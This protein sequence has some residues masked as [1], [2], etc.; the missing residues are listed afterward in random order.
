MTEIEISTGASSALTAKTW[1]SISWQK[2]DKQVTRL[3]MRIAKAER[4][5]K[6]GKVKALQRILTC[7]FYAKC[8]AVKRV[9]S[10]KGGKTP[11]VDGIIWKTAKQKIQATLSLKRHGYN[12]LPSR[13]INVPKKQKGKFR[14]IS[15]PTMKDKAMQALWHMALLPIAEERS[16]LN[17]YGFR[18]KR[19]T[20]DAIEQ[21]F[22]AL[23]KNE[24]PKWVFEGDIRSCFDKISHQW[25]LE[26]IPMDKQILRKFLKAGFM[27]KQ[28]L[29]PT[30]LGTEQG[31]TISPTLAIMALSGIE[32]KVR[33]TSSRQR[34]KE[35]INFVSYADDFIIT[36]NSPELLKGKV[37]PIVTEFLAERGLELSQEKSKI[38]H[39]DEGF[40]FLGL[41]VRKY[42]GKLLIK[43]AK[44]NIKTFLQDIRSAIK[45]N[46]SAKTENLINLLNPKIRGWANY[47]CSAVSSKAFSYVDNMIYRMLKSWLLRRHSDKS[48]SW[49][50]KKYYIRRGLS[51]WN[52]HAMIKDKKGNKIPFYLYQAC[53][54]PIA[55][56]IK[57]KGEAHPFNPKFKDYFK[58]RDKTSKTRLTSS[59]SRLKLNTRLLGDNVALLRA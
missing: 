24:S 28:K 10:N 48:K 9:V 35:Q 14:P 38:T 12:P 2:I 26:N 30:E 22:K 57:I 42:K 53:K 11:G 7:S 58:L 54:T 13:R 15:I 44:E 59:N 4:E 3:Q 34:A 56:H 23:C 36:G 18:P 8:L 6:K 19:S 46:Y 27:E 40:N 50:I 43:P 29:Y 5:G 47:F 55:R 17:S 45:A 52:F 21:C 20:R 49:I 51:K 39:I 33:S 41:N 32:R 25:L 37:I 31:S 1:D 16:D